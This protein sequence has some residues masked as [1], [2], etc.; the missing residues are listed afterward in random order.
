MT[1]PLVTGCYDCGRDWDEDWLDLWVP[2]DVWNQI[3]PLPDGRGYLCHR[4]V[5]LAVAGLGLIDVQ[6]QV[7]GGPF[8]GANLVSSL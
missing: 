3:A 7:Y 4:C 8:G 6:A 1:P 5:R 2:D